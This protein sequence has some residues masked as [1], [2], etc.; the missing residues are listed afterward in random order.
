MTPLLH[1]SRHCNFN[2]RFDSILRFYC[3]PSARGHGAANKNNNLK[4]NLEEVNGQLRY[5]GFICGLIDREGPAC[6]FAGIGLNSESK[7]TIS[8]KIRFQLAR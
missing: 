7:L 5:Y 4:E 1:S 8:N 3:V 2:S 6:H